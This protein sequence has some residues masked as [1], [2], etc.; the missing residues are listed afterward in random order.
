MPELLN[1]NQLSERELR[2]FVSLLQGCEEK[3]LHLLAQQ[4]TKFDDA[5]LSLIERFVEASEDEELID[6]WFYASKLNLVSQI[7]EW[8]RT[9]DLE[10]G[11]FLISRFKNPGLEE[12]K[13]KAILDNYAHRAAQRLTAS[14]PLNKIIAAINDVFYKEENYIGNQ[15]D[16]YD[17]D[18]NFLHRVIERKTGNPITM[19]CLYML[20]ARRLGLEVK[21]VGT[22]GHFILKIEEKLIDPFFYGREVTKDE[23][24]V[25]AQEL[26][27]VWRD[28]YLDTIDDEMIV[29]RSIRNLITIYKKQNDFDKA[30]DATSLLKLV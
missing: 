2:G 7:Q 13:Y 27:V 5:S 14:S 29:S 3:T 22:P 16:Y 4:M 24:I 10:S 23:C 28:E 19:S 1:K 20:V 25:R 15:I 8:K 11:L 6:N 12:D 21:G 17:A 18:N 9:P 26:N 30:A